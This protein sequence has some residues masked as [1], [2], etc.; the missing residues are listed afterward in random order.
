[1]NNL[2]MRVVR[3]ESLVTQLQAQLATFAAVLGQLAQNQQLGTMP[4]S[5][6][7]SANVFFFIPGTAMS[8]TGVAP[9]SGMPSSL[10]G[11]TVYQISSGS[12]ITATTNGTVYCAMPSGVA[13]GFV[14]VLLPNGDGTYSAI[15]QSCV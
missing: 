11:Q 4:P 6:S 2:D 13:S 8:G 10:T 9:P 1:M 5:A 14:T 15:G 7:G 3:L 12:F